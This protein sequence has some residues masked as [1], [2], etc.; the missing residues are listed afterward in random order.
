MNHDLFNPKGKTVLQ[1]G[2]FGDVINFLPL[3]YEMNLAG[4]RLS[5][6]VAN[7]YA[8]VLD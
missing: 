2:R 7:E 8:D 4:S 5:M 1:L 3:A 6:V